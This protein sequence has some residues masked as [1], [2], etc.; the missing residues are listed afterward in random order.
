MSW[1]VH[2]QSMPPVDDL[3]R[4]IGRSDPD[5]IGLQEIL[6]PQAERLAQLLGMSHVWTFKHNPFWPLL[7]GRAEGLAVLCGHA[8]RSSRSV[9]LS[10]GES[11]RS[12]ARRVAMF[13]DVEI[14]GSAITIVNTHLASHRRSFERIRQSKVLRKEIE[15]ST[16]HPWLMTADLND[17]AE[18]RVVDILCG[19]DAR[20]GWTEVHGDLAGF[21]CPSRAPTMRL[22]HVLVS[23]AFT[24]RAAEVLDGA[25]QPERLSDHLPVVVTTHI[26]GSVNRAP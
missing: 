24:V 7:D 21:T 18:H 5:V 8:I 10:D 3:A 2:G 25:P 11:R 6:R 13:V 4:V 14:S 9:V 16:R 12:H 23:G 17:H 1:N 20:D 22:D 15:E 26:L 19:N